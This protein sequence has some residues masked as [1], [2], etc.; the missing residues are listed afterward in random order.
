MMPTNLFSLGDI[1]AVPT[2]PKEVFVAADRLYKARTLGEIYEIDFPFAVTALH[3]PNRFAGFYKDSEG[4]YPGSTYAKFEMTPHGDWHV[5]KTERLQ[6][7][8]MVM[9]FAQK[10]LVDAQEEETIDLTPFQEAATYVTAYQNQLQG[11]SIHPEQPTIFRAYLSGH[12]MHGSGTHIDYPE[13]LP[14]S[15]IWSVTNRQGTL[16]APHQDTLDILSHS[17]LALILDLPL[18]DPQLTQYLKAMANTSALRVRDETIEKVRDQLKE[19]CVAQPENSINLSTG[20]TF[21]E[22]PPNIYN[23]KNQRNR[24]Y[25]KVIRGHAP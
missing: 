6:F 12:M 20:A 22:Q 23:S 7:E 3:D 14:Q 1:T 21:H 9:G 4:D 10:K 13:A 11:I 25:L 2:L 5:V 18:K 15:L 19:A 16:T 8:G 17:E 24:V